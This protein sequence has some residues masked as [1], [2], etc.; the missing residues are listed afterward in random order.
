M[1][2]EFQSSGAAPSLFSTPTHLFFNHSFSLPLFRS[3][4]TFNFSYCALNSATCESVNAVA[5][6]IL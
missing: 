2:N 1:R 4:Y 6:R 3:L 5:D